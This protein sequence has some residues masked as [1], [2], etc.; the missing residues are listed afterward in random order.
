MVEWRSVVEGRYP[1][2]LS[3]IIARNDPATRPCG[4]VDDRR[5]GSDFIGAGLF[6]IHLVQAHS[7]AMV[8]GHHRTTYRYCLAY[9]PLFFFGNHDFTQPRRIPLSLLPIAQ[10]S[11]TQYIP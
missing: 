7:A 11:K 6:G 5:L 2:R 4:M 1:T 8:M 9:G 3:D 10:L